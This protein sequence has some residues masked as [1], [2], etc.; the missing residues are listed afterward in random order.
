MVRC[1]MS[2]MGLKALSIDLTGV[3]ALCMLILDA[4]TGFSILKYV[5]DSCRSRLAT[6]LSRI[7]LVRK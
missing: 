7:K 2:Y 3:P 5:S 6:T 1:T 4:Y